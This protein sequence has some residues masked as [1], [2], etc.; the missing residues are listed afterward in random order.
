MCNAR[1]SGTNAG[2]TGNRDQ[3]DGIPGATITGRRNFSYL[4]LTQ[5]CHPI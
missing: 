4:W 2:I 1:A 5:V 3:S